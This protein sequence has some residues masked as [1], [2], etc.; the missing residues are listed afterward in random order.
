MCHLPGSAV[1]VLHALQSGCTSSLRFGDGGVK[2]DNVR[3]EF[4]QISHLKSSNY[5]SVGVQ[6]ALRG[7]VFPAQVVSRQWAKHPMG[8]RPFLG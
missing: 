2:K 5:G 6:E 3:T 4:R 8:P 1:V 7:L